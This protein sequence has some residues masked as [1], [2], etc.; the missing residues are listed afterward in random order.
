MILLVRK[1]SFRILT[2]IFIV[3][4]LS[5]LLA[6]WQ[7]SISSAYS[8]DLFV[9]RWQTDVEGATEPTKVTLAFLKGATSK[10][11]VSWK[12]DGAFEDVYDSKITH[13]YQESGTFDVCIKTT[14]PFRLHI[15]S[16]AD[17][18]KAK[19][20]EIKQWGHVPWSSFDSA[21][22][23]AVNMQLTATDSPD[24]SAVTSM[25][26]AFA[27]TTNFTGHD[28]MNSWDTSN[29]TSMMYTFWNASQFNGA[30]SNWDTSNVTSI[31][32]MFRGTSKFNQPIGDWNTENIIGMA[33]T[34]NGATAFNQDVSNWNTSSVKDMQTMFFGATEFNQPLNPKVVN[35]GTPNEY[36]SWDTKDV[37]NML[38]MF[39]NAKA[40]NQNIGG[41]DTSSVTSMSN[42]FQGATAFNNGDAPGESQNTMNWDTRNVE[43]MSLMFRDAS[44]F[45]QY[46]G[47][48]NTGLVTNMANMFQGA[49]NFNNGE[50]P[51]ENSNTM[52]WDTKSL[53]Y[54]TYMFLNA[55]AFNQNIGSWDTSN[56]T[57]ML[58]MFMNAS[59]FNQ[60]LNN[61]DTRKVTSMMHMFNGATVFNNGDVAGGSSNPLNLDT[62][63][64]ENMYAMFVARDFNQPFGPKWTTSSVKSMSDMFRQARSFNQ[65]IGDWDTSNVTNMAYMFQNANVFNN[66]AELGDESKPLN[67]NTAKVANMSYMFDRAYEFNQPFGNNWDT[68]IV[69]DMTRMF[70]LASGF[71]QDISGWQTGNVQD[72]SYMFSA[73]TSFNQPIGSWNTSNV[74]NMMFML[75]NAS[76]FDQDISD[77]SISNVSRISYFLNYTAM[78]PYNYD[79]L[80]T[81]WSV[82]TVKP[83]LYMDAVGVYYCHA[84]PARDILTSTPK[85]WRINDAGQNC[86][87]LNLAL[88]NNAE[89][90]ENKTEVGTISATDETT[91]IYSLVS[92]EGSADNAKFALNPTTG[93]LAFLEAPDY[94]SPT[95]SAD[96]GNLN[97][98]TIRVR[99]T[100]ATDLY[101]EKVFIIT[102]LDVDDLPPEINI[103]TP[104]NKMSNA[105]ITT[106]FTVSDR[107]SVNSVEVDSS[108][109]ATGDNI[110]CDPSFPANNTAENPEQN[111]LVLNCTVDVT[112]SGKLV[113]KATDKAGYSSTATMEGY[114]IDEVAPVFVVSSIDTTTHNLHKPIVK[115]MAFDAVGIQKYEIRYIEDNQGE[116]VSP[117]ET[118]KEIEYRP[119]VIEETLE[120]DPHEKQHTITVV[121]YDLAGNVTEKQTIFPPEVVFN[122]PTIL[123]NQPISDSTVTITAPVDEHE[124]N[125]I[126]ISGSASEG[127]TLENCADADGEHD[128]PYVT[129]VTC[130]I[131]NINK[132]GTLTVQAKDTNNGA[133]GYNSQMYTI[134]TVK[135]T[136]TI[137]APTKAKKDNIINTTI[138]VTD[139]VEIYPGS[140]EI[141]ESSKTM[142]ENL[143]CTVDTGD[144]N[145][146][147][148]TVVIKG[149]GDLAITAK[150]KAGNSFTKIEEGY[151]ID[152]IP[153]EVS[154]TSES[155]I[156]RANR[157]HYVLEGTCT[158]GDNS[159]ITII[160]EQP[161]LAECQD[162]DTWSTTLD[163]SAQP[164]GTVVVYAS[165][166]DSVGNKGEDTKE[167]LK[168]TVIPVADFGT[169]LTKSRSPKLTGLV[170][171]ATA[172][173]QVKVADKTYDADNNDDGTWKLDAG[174]IDPE[175]ANG[176]YTVSVI[177]TDTALNQGTY[178][179]ID[180]LTVDATDPV[181]TISPPTKLS[182]KNIDNIS[183]TVTD[184]NSILAENVS[185]NSSSTA[186]PIDLVCTQA[187][188]KKVN[189]TVTVTKSGNLIINAIDQAT[190]SAS[191]TEDDFVIDRV[192]PAVSITSDAPINNSNKTNYPL[193]GTCTEGDGDITINI[194]GQ[195]HQTACQTGD[196][197][198]EALD[199]SA[200]TE[201]NIS[202][203]ASQTDMA[204]NKGT[205]N[206]SL[207]KDT[208]VP[209][210]TINLAEGQAELT[211]ALP[212]KFK[213][214]FSKPVADFSQSDV[215]IAGS[216]T[217][218]IT[219]FTTGAGEY[220]QD[221]W[222]DVN[223]ATDGDQIGLSVAENTAK[224]EAGNFNEA[225]NSSAVVSFDTTKPTVI[226]DRAEGQ[227]S[228][229]TE[230][231]AKFVLTFSEPIV[232]LKTEDLTVIGTTGSVTGLTKLSSIKYLVEIKGM[233]DGD[234]AKLA[235][236]ANKVKD[237]AG[238]FNKA[239]TSINDSVLYKTQ[240]TP[241]P[242]IV[243][244]PVVI[245]PDSPKTVPTEQT[246]TT[247]FI[248]QKV[249]KTPTVWQPDTT[250]S[251]DTKK[252]ETPQDS[253]E[254]TSQSKHLK[255]KV[256][257]ESHQPV[258]GVV[259]EIHSRVRTKTTN[260]DGEAYFKDVETGSHT[261][262][263]AYEDQRVEKKI[264]LIDD[265]KEELEIKVKL[266][267][268]EEEKECTRWLIIVIILLLIL[269]ARSMYK[270]KQNQSR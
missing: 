132:S 93:V 34:F 87:P 234:I 148:C 122:A 167:L 137:S 253:R 247:P 55:K 218:T 145:I 38:R 8:A 102:V 170:N 29:V 169:F 190:N 5:T 198:S 89:I 40:F 203:Q 199:L 134:D 7:F 118:V 121:A 72:M 210:T 201:G 84:K 133:I 77:W 44:A 150:D 69:T 2:G 175:L 173:V 131:K 98:Y 12:C 191:K 22:R 195:S 63:K 222:I 245:L 235:L 172:T 47:G 107:Y 269:L 48:W 200:L 265:G 113:L 14:D 26:F 183:V 182:N 176:T 35:P 90:E 196:T 238:N 188:T 171:D 10:Y 15:S 254:T 233:T 43:G 99:A 179:F 240:S 162:G 100:D 37:K 268:A 101:S 116:G 27:D 13:D 78:H 216:T 153:P 242:P 111:H 95:G 31:A 197:W 186:G 270:N 105:P 75:N 236:E 251:V 4:G 212:I 9:T 67:W 231:S 194:A 96:P 138:T 32:H 144:Q 249:Y 130:N 160:A 54:V 46:I 161:Y 6:V 139:D 181:I 209:T 149:S 136:I 126:E 20:L 263:V 57:G 39:Q 28:S 225:S 18:E 56:V 81:D 156:N 257:D 211:N 252:D 115:F 168:D 193:E 82:Q 104:E 157:A 244:P 229:T 250:P 36:T 66:G 58:G 94:E 266:E 119:D 227:V 180:A 192:L 166:T 243:I 112:S 205:F 189:C 3:L 213:I 220:E 50:A 11:E 228:P 214:S 142:A 146:I 109:V 230:D 267:P 80:L 140:I 154:I 83:N 92:G 76:S 258:E 223:G 202:I 187:G 226:I 88:S 174:N 208:V 106:S 215:D 125:N 19:L 25:N 262:I 49:I 165:Q 159:V 151:V 141:A 264:N 260:S 120:L 53:R 42:M 232:E 261:M 85:N 65:Y 185:I 86:P 241:E 128:P 51:G 219:N 21:F 204:G 1:K 74:T 61:W 207:L 163:L 164:D 33:S 217:A 248:R 17:D 59:S 41:W 79:A 239:N 52:N 24:L 135:P 246:D 70:N 117:I 91:I 256:Y 73:A 114:V 206:K 178:D 224:D 255:I 23:G 155:P 60:N 30:I 143:E 110:V 103:V 68:S 152:R 97:K 158:Y 62:S 237:L 16:L 123:S 108:S 64:V 259:I 45:N 184:N 177:A 71:N 147:N 129:S 221:F 124:I 127:V